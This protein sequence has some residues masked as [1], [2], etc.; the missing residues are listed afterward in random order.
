MFYLFYSNVHFP[1]SIYSEHSSIPF[2]W[3]CIISIDLSYKYFKNYINLDY[4]QIWQND[5]RK[6]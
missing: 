3:K 4:P 6:N 2:Y 5:P 1:V